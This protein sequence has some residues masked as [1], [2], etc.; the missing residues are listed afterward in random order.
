MSLVRRCN[1]DTPI[2]G[3]DGS[4][5]ISQKGCEQKREKIIRSRV[6]ERLCYTSRVQYVCTEQRITS[7]L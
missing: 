6:R 7:T 3:Y 5:I 4:D 2:S 1:I